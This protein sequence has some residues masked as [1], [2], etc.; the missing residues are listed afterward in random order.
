MK[1]Y[2]LGY[3]VRE[4]NAQFFT[5]LEHEIEIEM[6]D[7]THKIETMAPEKIFN[8][9]ACT[10]ELQCFYNNADDMILEYWR[11]DGQIDMISV[12]SQWCNQMR[13]RMGLV[14]FNHVL[15]N[16]Y[17]HF[18]AKKSTEYQYKPVST[19]Y[20]TEEISLHKNSDDQ[21]PTLTADLAYTQSGTMR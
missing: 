16:R 9:I 18:V 3:D 6:E 12:T 21:A 5:I 19:L 20:R 11:Q 4:K 7:D 13:G 8:L 17:Q 15:K 14:E 10:P 2:I 1:I